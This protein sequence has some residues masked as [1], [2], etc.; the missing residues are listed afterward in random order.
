MKQQRCIKGDTT[1]CLQLFNHV[2]TKA[3]KQF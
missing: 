3:T 1:T 2:K